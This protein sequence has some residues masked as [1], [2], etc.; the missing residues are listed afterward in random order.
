[1]SRNGI[2]LLGGGFIGM[3]PARSLAAESR[4]VHIVTRR[5][6]P[7]SNVDISVHV[8]DLAD[9]ALLKNLSSECSTVVHLASATLPGSSARHPVR[10]LDN[11]TPTLHLLETLQRWESTHVIFFVL[12]RNGVR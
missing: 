11:L 3:A 8:G 5:A 6:T 4:R 2:L 7:V 12:R 1:M 10:E 9:A